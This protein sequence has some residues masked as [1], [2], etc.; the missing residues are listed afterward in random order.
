MPNSAPLAALSGSSWILS[1]RSRWTRRCSRLPSSA[2]AC[3]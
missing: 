1:S 2:S 3:R